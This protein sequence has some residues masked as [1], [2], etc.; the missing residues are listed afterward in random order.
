MSLCGNVGVKIMARSPLPWI[1]GKHY[2]ARH[3]IT[4]FPPSANYDSYVELFGGGAH[5]LMQKKAYKHVECYNDLNGNLVNFWLQAR[6]NL[7]A[8][9]DRCRTLPYSRD[10]YYRYHKSLWDGS[11]L[12]ELERA[13]R[14]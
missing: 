5:V 3:I 12:E 4:Q 13:T 6:D 7:E 10:L 1:G 8:L 9:E 2:S 14:W 11:E